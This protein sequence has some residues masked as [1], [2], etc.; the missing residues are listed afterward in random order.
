M[1]KR[2]A[3]GLR[4]WHV[5]EIELTR[6][7]EPSLRPERVR[8]REVTCVTVQT[9][10][11]QVYVRAGREMSERSRMRVEERLPESERHSQRAKCQ[12]GTVVCNR[13]LSASRNRREQAECFLTVSRGEHLLWSGERQHGTYIIAKRK[14]I[15]RWCSGEKGSTPWG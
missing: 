11:R 6:C 12:A 1:R 7:D 9:P 14:C 5:L 3:R 2:L 4:E 15:S 8:E 13:S 10:W